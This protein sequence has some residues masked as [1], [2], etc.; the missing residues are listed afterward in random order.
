MHFWDKQEC[1]SLKYIVKNILPY[2]ELKCF[3]F[4]FLLIDIFFLF[5][6]VWAKY[7]YPFCFYY[8]LI[9]VI[10]NDTT[11]WT[12][13]KRGYNFLIL[14]N[15]I[16]GV[17]KK[18]GSA[19][20]QY[21]AFKDFSSASIVQKYMWDRPVA[22]KKQNEMHRMK[23]RERDKKREGEEEGRRESKQEGTTQADVPFLLM[24]PCATTAFTSL[25]LCCMQSTLDFQNSVLSMLQILQ[26]ICKAT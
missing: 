4:Y 2:S 3:A 24:H 1:I 20:I 17:E 23:Q 7:D 21:R 16:N 10:W 11:T 18:S 9:A 26:P 15:L 22:G 12:S 13:V 14:R 25:Q 6:F 8:L 5:S 19:F